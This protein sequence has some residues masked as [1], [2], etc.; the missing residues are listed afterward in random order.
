MAGKNA[1]RSRRMRVQCRLSQLHRKTDMH[2]M[3]LKQITK[4]T[5]LAALA[6]AAFTVSAQAAA[7]DRAAIEAAFTRADVNKDGMV[8]KDEAAKLPAIAAKFS[9]IDK[10]KDGMLNIEEFAAGY[11]APN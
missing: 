11:S 7:P 6:S 9:Q 5:L 10:D 8:S 4:A 2:T 3:Q 1:G